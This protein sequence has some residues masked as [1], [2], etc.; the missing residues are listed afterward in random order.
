MYLIPTSYD[1]KEALS[2]S[3]VERPSSWKASAS[4]TE[5]RSGQED[6]GKSKEVGKLSDVVDKNEKRHG[7]GSTQSEK[8]WKLEDLCFH[9]SCR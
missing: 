3:Y 2:L 5:E 1:L 6:E 4:G 8:I 7:A 9:C